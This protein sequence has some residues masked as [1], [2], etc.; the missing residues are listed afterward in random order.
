M[1][2]SIFEDTE[3]TRA[4]VVHVVVHIWSFHNDDITLKAHFEVKVTSS[5]PDTDIELYVRLRLV[6]H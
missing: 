6:K 2:V 4:A 1:I 5:V 3:T